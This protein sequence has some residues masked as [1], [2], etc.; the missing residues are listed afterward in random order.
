VVSGGQDRI[1]PPR[2]GREL[3]ERLSGSS[4]AELASAGHYIPLF[5]ADWFNRQIST[6]MNAMRP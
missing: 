6:F 4:Y 2:Y 1:T 3:A 5:N